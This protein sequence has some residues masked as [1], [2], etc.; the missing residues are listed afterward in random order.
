[1]WK[2]TRCVYFLR[3][4]D[5]K[6]RETGFELTQSGI[7]PILVKKE[8]RKRERSEVKWTKLNAKRKKT[9]IAQKQLNYIRWTTV[10]KYTNTHTHVHTRSNILSKEREENRA[11]KENFCDK[12]L[13][14]C[15]ILSDNDAMR[16]NMISKLFLYFTST[17][18]RKKNNSNNNSNNTIH[19]WFTFIQTI[20]SYFFSSFKTWQPFHELIQWLNLNR[21]IQSN[22]KLLPY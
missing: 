9:Q 20:Y 11:E 22:T 21:K 4:N 3:S 2:I 12:L 14:N 17:F 13:T 1:M 16:L 7:V 15:H 5:N 19:L 18:Q 8:R 6:K 10:Y